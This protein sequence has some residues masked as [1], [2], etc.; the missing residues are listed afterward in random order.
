MISIMISNRSSSTP[1][2]STLLGLGAGSRLPEAQHNQ[3]CNY[4]LSNQ[5]HSLLISPLP[6]PML[7]KTLAKE[8]EEVRSKGLEG[9]GGT[10][11]RAVGGPARGRVGSRCQPRRP[12][13]RDVHIHVHV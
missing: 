9:L 12:R 10:N 11:S 3:S 5:T 13:G 4:T 7:E 1:Y 8:L 6:S 2:L